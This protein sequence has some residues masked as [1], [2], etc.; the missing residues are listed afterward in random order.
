MGTTKLLKDSDDN[1]DPNLMGSRC[2]VF[3]KFAPRKRGRG[4]VIVNW[5]YFWL[6][7]VCVP[8]DRHCVSFM[9]YIW[10]WPCSLSSINAPCLVFSGLNWCSPP[11][12]DNEI[13][14]N[15]KTYWKKAIQTAHFPEDSSFVCH[16]W[17]EIANESLLWLLLCCL[18]V[19]GI[20]ISAEALMDPQ[21]MEAA[22]NYFHS[23]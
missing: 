13:G 11:C 15:L 3:V 14:P 1:Q 2:K 12:D 20:T 18:S 17:T 8:Y 9:C 19:L 10:T 21:P 4:E 6:N 16:V 5:P 7:L 23:S 22:V